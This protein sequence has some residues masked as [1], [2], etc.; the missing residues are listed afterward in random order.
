MSDVI[1]LMDN[2]NYNSN[3]NIT[4]KSKKNKSKRNIIDFADS[5]KHIPVKPGEYYIPEIDIKLY[6]YCTRRLF[7]LI[8]NDLK[9][10]GAYDDIFARQIFFAQ[11]GADENGWRMFE[12]QRRFQQALSSRL[13]DFHEELSGKLPG[14]RT[15]PQ[16]HWS[17]LDV[18]KEDRSEIYEWKNRADVSTDIL[19]TVYQKFKKI[20]DSGKIGRC[21]LVH[22]NVPDGWKPPAPIKRRQDGTVLIDL[23]TPKYAGRVYIMSGREAYAHMSGDPHFIDRLRMTMSNTFQDVSLQESLSRIA[24]TMDEA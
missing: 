20:L 14:Y 12:S 21:I 15:L 7:K 10:Y 23:T 19:T 13:G 5:L 6:Y 3:R 8:E 1:N 16:K 4:Q 2:N 17:G 11:T 24:Y 9:D 18:M 22:V